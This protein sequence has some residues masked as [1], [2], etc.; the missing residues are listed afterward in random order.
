MAN[1]EKKTAWKW[2]SLYIRTR[3]C[4]ETTRTK[5]HGKC[6]TCGQIF[7][8]EKLHA[9][10]CIG[11]RT[12]AILLDDEVVHAQCIRCNNYKS[13]NYENY[14]PIMITKH[15]LDWYNRKVAL[16]KLPVKIDFKAEAKKWREKYNNL[17]DSVDGY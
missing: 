8:I 10:H 4:I 2:F 6:I 11:G 9:G 1:A 5:T 12:N 17:K 16:S 13:G 15:S 14:I 3:D 7:P